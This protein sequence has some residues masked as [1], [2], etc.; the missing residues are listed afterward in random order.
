MRVIVAAQILFTQKAGGSKRKA[1]TVPKGKVLFKKC[2]KSL[3]LM[4]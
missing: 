3:L 4:S 1:A 2:P